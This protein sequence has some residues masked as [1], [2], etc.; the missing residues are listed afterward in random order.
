MNKNFTYKSILIAC[1]VNTA[2]SPM[3]EAFMKE[4]LKNNSGVKIQSCGVAS[5]ARD[6]MFIS[7]DAKLAMKEEGIK[8][9]DD[10][11]SIDIKKH[12]ELI[13]DVDLI[14]TLTE[15]HKE[16]IS[17]LQEAHGKEIYTLKEFAG[18]SGDIIDPSMKGLE[19]FRIAR[20]EIKRCIIKGLKKFTFNDFK[21]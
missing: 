17:E 19:G 14:L 21:L 12:R 3:A 20:N 18:E 10:S 5:N 9:S 13:K 2:R 7:M 4:Y 8:L 16:E 1:S 15:K 11:L 6:G